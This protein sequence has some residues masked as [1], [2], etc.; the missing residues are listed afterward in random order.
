MSRYGP[1]WLIVGVL[2]LSSWCAG[3]CAVISTNTTVSYPKGRGP[4]ASSSASRI[5]IG[6]TTKQW[7]V[8][9]LGPPTDTATV[10]MGVEVLHYVSVKKRDGSLDLLGL[11]NFK[12]S[13][14]KSETFFVRIENGVVT[15]FGRRKL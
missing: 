2:V 5:R 4:V 8:E 3:G 10:A 14:E 12:D 11:M 9:N 6:E 15:D 1:G 7:I 13:K